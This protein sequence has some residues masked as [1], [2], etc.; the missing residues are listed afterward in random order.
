MQ[1][2]PRD[3][4]ATRAAAIAQ[5]LAL[6]S[7]RCADMTPLVYARLFAERPETRALFRTEGSDL[8]KASMLELSIEAVLDF[9]GERR[10][11]HRTILCEVQSHEAYGT[12]P[13]LFGV[14]FRVIA[15]TARDVLGAEWTPAFESAWRDLLAELDA[16]VAQARQMAGFSSPAASAGPQPMSGEARITS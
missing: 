10:A 8:V 14:F 13:E 6:T 7:E 15:A 12:S 1:A 3:A 4:A 11:S 16:Y 2:M 9:A 5:S